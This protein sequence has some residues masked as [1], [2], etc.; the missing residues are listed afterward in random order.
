MGEIAGSIADNIAAFRKSFLC[1]VR[2]SPHAITVDMLQIKNLTFFVGGRLMFNN[3]TLNVPKG[4][5]IGLIG[6]NGSGKTTLFRLIIGDITPDSGSIL[7]HQQA[8]I[9]TVAQEAPSSSLSLLDAVLKEDK[10]RDLLL[11]ESAIASNPRRISEIHDRLAEI[12]AQTAPSRAAAIL[13]GLGFDEAAQQ[14]SC[15]DLSGGWR[16][17]VALAAAL[18]TRPDLLLLDE[19]TNHLDLEAVMWLEKYLARLK[20]TLIIISHERSLLNRTIGEIVHLENQRLTRYSGGYDDFERIRRYKLIQNAKMDARQQ[21]EKKRIQKFVER[22]RYKATKARQAQSRL[23]MLERMEPIPSVIEDRAISFEFPQ[24]DP[25]SP[26][27]IALDQAQAGYNG[28]AVLTDLNLRIDMEDRIA[29]LGPNGNGK[30]TLVKLLAGRLKPLS[31]KLVKSRKLTIGYFAQHQAEELDSRSSAYEHLKLTYPMEPETRIRSHLGRF[32]FEGSRADTKVANLSGG[33]KSRLLFCL[34]STEKPHLMLLD[35]PTNHLDIDSREALIA[36]LNAY[37]GA[38]ILVSHDLYLIRL[39]AD[40]LWLLEDGRCQPL[41]G[42]LDD[43]ERHLFEKRPAKRL[44]ATDRSSTSKGNK[45]DNRKQ[46]ALARNRFSS[47]NKIARDS[48]RKMEL[49]SAKI[50]ALEFKLADPVIYD[51]DGSEVETVQKHLGRAKKALADAEVV[52]LEA[53][54]FLEAASD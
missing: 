35:E 7:L 24:P 5:K 48:E 37:E 29:L 27:L 4:H 22:F 53:Q 50:E 38:I 31:G 43:Y 23:K 45:H 34:I 42:S 21:A 52:W 25:L 10:E 51:M 14:Q 30:S 1:F 11:E 17:R 12:E 20:G 26:P 16:M 15:S 49:L 54:E 13:S 32:G 9:G 40:R 33:E 36:A 19:P 41:E 28:K 46:R 8:K 18:F 6:Q 3:A 39:V 2:C 44:S 47:I